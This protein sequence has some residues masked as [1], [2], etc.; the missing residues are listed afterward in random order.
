MVKQL[1]VASGAGIME[2]K[3]VLIEAAGDND[4]AIEILRKS[5]QLKATQKSARIAAEGRILIR[6]AADNKTATMVEVNCET[7]FVAKDSQ[8]VEFCNAVADASLDP[9]IADKQGLEEATHG[10]VRLQDMHSSLVAQLGEK[11]EIRR[12]SKLSCGGDFLASY[13]HGTRIGVLLDLQGGNAALAKDMAMHIAASNPLCISEQEVPAGTIAKE[14]ALLVAQAKES[15]KPEALIERIVSGRLQKYLNGITLLKQD[16]VK[17]TEQTVA[18]RLATDKATVVAF[19]RYELG[20]GVARKQEDFNAEV[21]AQ[22]EQ[23]E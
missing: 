8:F 7:D 18:Q 20:E 9:A 2:C 16:F 23:H 14:R 5:G 12:F 13:S 21:M 11:I 1:R 4:R 10:G 19:V 15:G 3:K 17:D 6:L 22:I